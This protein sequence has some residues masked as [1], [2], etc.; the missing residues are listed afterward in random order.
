MRAGSSCWS[1]ALVTAAIVP[2][3]IWWPWATRSA[4]SRT[5]CSPARTAS[6]EPS[7][8]STLPRRKTLH[9]RWPS[10]ARSTAS[11]DPASSSAASLASSICLRTELLPDQQRH[12]LAVGASADR[13]HDRPHD[14]AHVLGRLGARGGD[15]LV[16]EPPELL[17]GQLGREVAAD[18]GRL[19]LL[20]GG[21]LLAPA[22][23]ELLGRVEPA[24][25]LAAQ[26]RHLVVTALLRR[27]LE[28]GEHQPQRP[29][30]LALAGLHGRRQ[31]AYDLFANRHPLRSRI[32]AGP[33][34]P[35]RLLLGGRLARRA[36]PLARHRLVLGREP[37]VGRQRLLF[38]RRA[39]RAVG[40]QF[41]VF[42]WR[43]MPELGELG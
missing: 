38:G 27:L 26:H 40:L 43:R 33:A 20:L 5:T 22:G 34:A 17:V 25:A 14:L 11:S 35:A 9:S 18:Q 36:R 39:P 3:A 4:S 30:A 16:D 31:V 21:Q 15:L 42:Q 7:S 19:R 8:V 24:L 32:G 6:S 1:S 12:A 37:E 23:A 28:L 2:G 41:P 10:S 13:R 29:N